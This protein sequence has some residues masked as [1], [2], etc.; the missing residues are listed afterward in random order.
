MTVMAGR[1][2][3]GGAPFGAVDQ[4]LSDITRQAFASSNADSEHDATPANGG[5]RPSGS[6]PVTDPVLMLTEGQR[7]CLRLV[8]RH[9]TSKDIAR[10][11]NV[12][13]HTV[14]MR[15]RTAMKTLGVDSR[16]DAARLLVAFETGSTAY[17]SLIYQSSELGRAGD[18]AMVGVPASALDE[19]HAVQHP[20]PRSSPDFGPSVP[21]PPRATGAPLASG[22]VARF[23]P[24]REVADEDERRTPATLGQSLPWGDRNTLGRGPRL[25][26]IA[27]IAIGSALSFGAILGALEALKRLL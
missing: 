8:F 17:Q 6:G 1:M 7:D 27:V 4:R 13:P 15:L 20:A 21:G 22:G 11:L 14:D 3:L 24:G 10:T 23:A 18:P 12:S 19:D 9:M 5:A 26:W 2:G 16:I 25:A